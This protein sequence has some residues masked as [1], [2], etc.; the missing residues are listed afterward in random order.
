M[1]E[2]LQK[3]ADTMLS[4]YT[5]ASVAGDSGIDNGV[6]LKSQMLEV[7]AVISS[8]VSTTK[9]ELEEKNFWQMFRR[10]RQ[11]KNDR[12]PAW[13]YGPSIWGCNY[14]DSS[15]WMEI[16][17]GGSESGWRI[18]PVH[19]SGGLC[20]DPGV[21]HFASITVYPSSECRSVRIDEQET[22]LPHSLG[23]DPSSDGDC[24]HVDQVEPKWTLFAGVKEEEEESVPLE[25]SKP[26]ERPMIHKVIQSEEEEEPKEVPEE[27]P[28]ELP[29][30]KGARVSHDGQSF[31]RPHTT[32]ICTTDVVAEYGMAP[33][34]PPSKPEGSRRRGS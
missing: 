25:A 4:T 29:A 10:L 23:V 8:L 7:Q 13:I 1:E 17:D 32:R 21:R 2:A 19:K 16:E 15:F 30:P 26:E 20:V 11:K 22:R 9:F 34:K 6:L 3:H 14:S 5:A 24:Q 27:E 12:Y 28:K 33:S 31:I 18:H